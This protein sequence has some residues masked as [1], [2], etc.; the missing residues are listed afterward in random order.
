MSTTTTA[1]AIRKV[2]AAICDIDDDA[3]KFTTREPD[4]YR[5]EDD[6]HLLLTMKNGDRVKIDVCGMRKSA[7]S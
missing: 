4:I 5:H 7:F 1:R 3:M 2:V 6:V